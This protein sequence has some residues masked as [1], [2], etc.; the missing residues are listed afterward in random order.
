[1]GLRSAIR[2]IAEVGK[3]AKPPTGVKPAWPEEDVSTRP[4]EPVETWTEQ[5]W[6]LV[7]PGG[8]IA[9]NTYSS[10]F[11]HNALDR[12]HM[13]SRLQLTAQELGFDQEEFLANYSWVTRSK[14]TAVQYGGAV[15]YLLNDPQVS[16]PTEEKEE[17]S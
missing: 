15:S 8:Q 10:V 1:M 14:T 11:F 6:G 12:L 7:L 5:E 2:D 13:I 9:W 4:E 16:V 17:E 3:I